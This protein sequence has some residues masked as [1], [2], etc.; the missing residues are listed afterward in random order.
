MTRMGYGPEVLECRSEL[1][2]EPPSA[3]VAGKC[4]ASKN[5]ASP[6]LLQIRDQ[7][8]SSLNGMKASQSPSAT[9]IPSRTSANPSAQAA[10]RSTLHTVARSYTKKDTKFVEVRCAL[11]AAFLRQGGGWRGLLR[12]H[13]ASAHCEELWGCL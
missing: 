6:S 2:R 5:W 3:G 10:L 11:C 7:S 4:F 13:A 1:A 12:R 9:V 8:K